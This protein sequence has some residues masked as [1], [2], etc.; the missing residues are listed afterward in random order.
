MISHASILGAPCNIPIHG[1]PTM[2]IM[3][4]D[5]PCIHGIHAPTEHTM[6]VQHVCNHVISHT[7]GPHYGY[8][9]W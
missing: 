3:S 8:H 5:I 9:E 2:D 7:W 1:V 6:V 4:G